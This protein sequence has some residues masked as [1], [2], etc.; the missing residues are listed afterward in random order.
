MADEIALGVL[1]PCF[2][3]LLIYYAF[4]KLCCPCCHECVDNGCSKCCFQCENLCKD[5]RHVDKIFRAG[6]AILGEAGD[7]AVK[8]DESIEWLRAAEI[9]GTIALNELKGEHL[10]EGDISEEEPDTEEEE[11]DEEKGVEASDSDDEKKEAKAS[12]REERAQ[13]NSDRKERHRE[14]QRSLAD[15]AGD[16]AHLFENG[17]SPSDVSQGELGD[18]WLL[19]AISTLAEKKGVIEQAFENHQRSPWG[20]YTIRIFDGCHRVWKRIVV[21]DLIPCRN[22]TPIFTKP[23]GNEMWVLLLEK[24]FAKYVGDYG[25]L[26]GGLPLWAMEAITGANVMH[27]TLMSEGDRQGHWQRMKLVHEE[28]KMNRR[29]CGLREVDKPGRRGKEA[30]PN[31]EFFRILETYEKTDAA[32]AAYS[33][34]NSDKESNHGIVAGHAYSILSVRHVRS[35]HK[36]IRFLQLRNPWGTFEWDGD[37]SD[38]SDLWEKHP[39]VASKLKFE[40]TNGD[41][42]NGDGVFWMTMDDFIKFFKGVDI[43]D[44]EVG[45]DDI[46]L[47]VEGQCD[48]CDEC[49][50]TCKED[51][52][53]NEMQR[54]CA[55]CGGCMKGCARYWCC[56]EGAAALCCYHHTATKTAKAQNRC[57]RTCD[58][59]ACGACECCDEDPCCV[60][61]GF[62]CNDKPY[63]DE[64]HGDTCLCC[65][66]EEAEEVP[67]GLPI[68]TPPTTKEEEE[69][70]EEGQEEPEQ[71]QEQESAAQDTDA[72]DESTSSST[73]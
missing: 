31:E 36:E 45:I 42:F 24:A 59:C 13:R 65:L 55:P 40:S 67:I 1:I 32:M 19:S 50:E 56:C 49:D 22:G 51:C 4:E 5:A 46:V 37:W 7:G 66:Q 64:K 21:D 9:C 6:P 11:E 10:E 34:G 12:E 18:C 72:V 63:R 60:D 2:F 71:E 35:E 25:K 27:F 8:N 70:M 52:C 38:K 14:R 68:T 48:V 43:L 53:I 33:Y 57:A 44:R 41:D 20:R 26:E 62:G 58:E 47:H 54:D 73:I 69:G 16:L 28:T 30:Y 17:I 39:D 3:C 23:H 61:G 29:K 15:A